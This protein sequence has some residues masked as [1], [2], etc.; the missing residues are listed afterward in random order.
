MIP[1]RRRL[2]SRSSAF[3][4]TLCL[5]IG[6]TKRT[7]AQLWEVPPLPRMTAAQ[8]VD[9]M[10]AKVGSETVHITVCRPS[11][12]HFLATPGPETSAARQPWM[13]GEKESCPGAKFTFSQTAEAAILTTDILKIEFSLKWGNVNYSTLEGSSTALTTLNIAALPPMP[14]ANV[15]MATREKAGFFQRV[16]TP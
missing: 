7:H 8:S 10:T 2:R 9:G 5:L 14:S 12:I 11:V 13:L 1:T 15:N 16:R 4:L 6:S 3:L